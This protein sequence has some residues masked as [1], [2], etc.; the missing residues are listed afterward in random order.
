[1]IVPGDGEAR[2]AGPSRED[3][4]VCSKLQDKETS[5]CK[6]GWPDQDRSLPQEAGRLVKAEPAEGYDAERDHVKRCPLC[7]TYYHYLCYYEYL[8]NGSEDE[9]ELIRITVEEA[10]G[11]LARRGLGLPQGDRASART[12]VDPAPPSS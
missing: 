11:L 8:V 5:F 1:V 2:S 3:C 7:G 9:E 12:P 4:P 6:Y 10:A